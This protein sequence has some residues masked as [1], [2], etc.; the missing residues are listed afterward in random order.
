M[1][2]LVELKLPNILGSEKVAIEKA[3][4]IAE[5]MGFSMDKI[6]DLKTALAEAC[7]NAIEHGNKF[8]KNTQVGITFASDD[9]SL[10]VVVHDEGDG[11]D[12][13]KI[14]KDRVDKDGLPR[15]RGYGVFLIS[16]LVNEFSIEKK[17]GKGNN[18]KMLIHLNR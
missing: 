2:Q 9:T 17:P 8:D 16:N 12:P 10:Q 5:K 11:I 6:E 1:E 18:V 13:K 3:A 7:I 4:T 14:P 15:R